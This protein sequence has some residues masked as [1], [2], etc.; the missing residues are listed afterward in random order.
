VI[1]DFG[2]ER[3]LSSAYPGIRELDLSA[4]TKVRFEFIAFKPVGLQVVQCRD[5]KG[6]RLNDE[7]DDVCES[8]GQVLYFLARARCREP[9]FM[10]DPS[11]PTPLP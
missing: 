1:G 4:L 5:V 11:R 2:A 3:A 9:L 7:L 10:D 8:L 6:Y